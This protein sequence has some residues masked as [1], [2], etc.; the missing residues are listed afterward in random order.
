MTSVLEFLD[1]TVPRAEGMVY[2]VQ[3]FPYWSFFVS[4]KIQTRPGHLVS[5]CFSPHPTTSFFRLHECHASWFLALLSS[6]FLPWAA[7]LYSW[8]IF[9]SKFI[10]H[11]YRILCYVDSPFSKNVYNFL[12]FFSLPRRTLPCWVTLSLLVSLLS[13]APSRE[14]SFWEEHR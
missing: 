9:I 3:L 10:R 1:F 6:V 8:S 13:S 12:S 2:H 4:L 5:C 11:S 14:H 7:W